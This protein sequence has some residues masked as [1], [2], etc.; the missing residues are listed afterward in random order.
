[1]QIHVAKS[2]GFCAGVKRAIKCAYES[3]G[4]FGRIEMLCD[5]VHNEIVVDRIA[6]LGILKVLS[7]SP[8]SNK[9]LLIRAHGAPRSVYTEARSHGYRIIDATCPMVTEIH[10]TARQIEQ[11]DRR[12]IIIGDLG[13][14]EVSGIAGQI[15]GTALVVPSAEALTDDLLHGITRAGVVVQSTQSQQNVDAI[16]KILRTRIPDLEFHNTICAATRRRQADIQTMPLHNVVMLIIGS[17]KSANTRRLYELSRQLNPRTYRILDANE[18][19]PRWLDG[20]QTVGVTADA[21][22]PDESIKAVIA[23]LTKISS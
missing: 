2:A 9:T 6:E 11:D 12:V 15:E 16:L 8:G 4:T 1:M 20:T 19:D 22:T 13:H 21:S 3:A 18:I 5:I 23:L 10:Q 14:E 17:R 7:L